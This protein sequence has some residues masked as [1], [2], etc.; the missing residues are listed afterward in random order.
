MYNDYEKTAGLSQPVEL[1]EF[2]TGTTTWRYTSAE[3]DMVIGGITYQSIYIENSEPGQTGE[4]AKDEL[5]IT[6][7]WDNPVFQQFLNYVPTKETKVTMLGY[8]RADV[9]DQ[10]TIF[11]WSGV[12]TKHDKQYPKA[13]LFFKPE[14]FEIKKKALSPKYGPDCQWTQFTG[15]C[16]L[17][18]A[19]WSDAFTVTAITGL[20]VSISGVLNDDKYLGGVLVLGVG[21]D[22]E[23]AM[24]TAQA[25]GQITID[26][27]LP[28]LVNGVACKLT[29]ACRG[30]FTLCDT[31]FSNRGNFIGAPYAEQTN[32]YTGDGVKGE[33]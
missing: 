14:D 24:I 20:V 9:I 31:V 6:V 5:K 13:V 19:A 28:S 2:V 29:Q 17:I 3:V 10:E 21:S 22:I 23:R 32:S 33:K 26:R 11:I 27:N 8:Q 25:A 15:R 16:G 4:E 30:D 1:Y 12:Q 7:D 18:E